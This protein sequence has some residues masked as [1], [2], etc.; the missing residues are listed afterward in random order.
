MKVLPVD[1]KSR[2]T[3]ERKIL[4]KIFVLY[5]IQHGFGSKVMKIKNICN[6]IEKNYKLVI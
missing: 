2:Q 4:Q 3:F 1:R 6:Y 5:V